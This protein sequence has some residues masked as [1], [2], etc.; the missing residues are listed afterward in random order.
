[1]VVIST[2]TPRFAISQRKPRFVALAVLVLSF[3]ATGYCGKANAAGAHHASGAALVRRWN[4]IAI[5]ASGLDHTPVPPGDSRVFGEQLGPG[6]SSRA[7]AIVHIAIFDAINAISGGCRTYTGIHPDPAASMDSAIV[8]AAHDTLAALF[9]SQSSK[10]ETLMNIDLSAMPVG[11]GNAKA[12][13]IALG[14]TAANAI[15][16]LR[17]ND[18]S[19][20]PDPHVGVD[21][22]PSLLPGMWRQDPIS[23]LG[24]AMGAYWGDVQPFVLASSS[25]YRAPVPPALNS[26]E[27]TSAYPEYTSAYDDVKSIGGDGIGTPTTR[28]PEQTQVGIFWAYDGTPSLCA[29]PRLYNQIAVHI[30]DQMGTSADV[31]KFSR[32]L[33]PAWATAMTQPSAIADGHRW[34]RRPAI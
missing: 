24:L 5:D 3:G 18:G 33:R 20:I 12:K 8:I 19:Q 27:Y 10:F 31:E 16:A 32:L 6:R 29:P 1:M 9:P 14:H 23:L 34:V 17:A 7:M 13:G 2:R 11:Q 22:I 15:L 4:K 25:Q 28:T 21:F 26:P 30:A